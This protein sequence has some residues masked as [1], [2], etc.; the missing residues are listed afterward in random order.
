MR[1]WRAT[2]FSCGKKHYTG[3]KQKAEMRENE[4]EK[5]EETETELG[6]TGIATTMRHSA[7]SVTSC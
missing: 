7:V 4:Q 6:L 2:G 3:K 1:V 5:A